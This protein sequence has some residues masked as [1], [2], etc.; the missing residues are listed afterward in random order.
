MGLAGPVGL[1]H[2]AP[3][4][5]A[6]SQ[7]GV[8]LQLARRN[9]H[10]DVVVTGLGDTARV[11]TQRGEGAVGAMRDLG[12]QPSHCDPDAGKVL[13]CGVKLQHERGIQ[14]EPSVVGPRREGGVESPSPQ[15]VRLLSNLQPSR[16]GSFPAGHAEFDREG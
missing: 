13:L 6:R 1:I 16:R 3:P 12:L 4:V 8:T 10:V 11:V 7:E 2:A 9:R 15:L 5:Q 14:P